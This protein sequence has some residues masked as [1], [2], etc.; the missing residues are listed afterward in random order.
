MPHYPEPAPLS[1]VTIH[2]RKI[3]AK[4]PSSLEEEAKE[5]ERSVQEAADE[6]EKQGHVH[7]S[8]QPWR[9]AMYEVWALTRADPFG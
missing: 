7:Y 8:D 9:K 2:T 5:A 3:N 6:K 4:S 1:S